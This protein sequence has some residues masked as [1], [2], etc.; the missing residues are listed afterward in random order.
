MERE[1]EHA[2]EVAELEAARPYLE[3]AREIRQQVDAAAGGSGDEAGALRGAVVSVPSAER[4]RLIRG[5]FA[6]LAPE[7][8]WAVLARAFGDEEIR[9][10]LEAE[11]QA[12]LDHLRRTAADHAYV[13]ASREE[14]RLDLT[15][16]PP[17]AELTLGLFLPED[18][19]AAVRRGRTSTVCARRLVVRVAGPVG[20]TAA[21]GRS[22]DGPSAEGAATAGLLHVIEDVFD[23]GRSLFVTPEYDRSAWAR[24]RLDDH[25]RVRIGSATAD[26]GDRLEPVLY[27]GGR[28]DVEQGGELRRGPLHLG[29]AVIGDEDV[30]AP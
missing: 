1:V 15:A 30:F 7:E 8:Q 21:G 25:A 19:R 2:R 24:D 27:P 20:G 11:R 17:R 4:D 3:L 29:F 13:V 28:F 23:P 26:A 12:G 16:L 6:R 5:V 14:R 10:H 18:V 9:S 22:D